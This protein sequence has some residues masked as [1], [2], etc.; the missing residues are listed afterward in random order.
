M[1]QNIDMPRWQVELQ[2]LHKQNSVLVVSGNIKDSVPF[3]V[4]GAAQ[5]LTNDLRL[6]LYAALCSEDVGPYAVVALLDQIDGLVF[7]DEVIG[8]P[9]GTEPMRVQ[10]GRLADNSQTDP[11]GGGRRGRPTTNDGSLLATLA[12]A[13]AAL[14]QT[15][16][17]CAIIVDRAAEACGPAS[18]LSAQ[19]REAYLQVLRCAV[20]AQTAPI[21]SAGADAPTR[22]LQNLLLLV[23]DRINDLPAFLWHDNAFVGRIELTRPKRDE[24]RRFFER[25]FGSDMTEAVSVTEIVDLTDGLQW[26]DLRCVRDVVQGAV[27][28]WTS[29]REMPKPRA[30]SLV[31]G[32]KFGRADSEWDAVDLDRLVH[33]EEHLTKR[34][35]GQP[36]AVRAGGDMLRR[37]TLGLAGAQQSSPTRPRGVL[38][39]AGPTGTGKTEL[40]RAIA[41]LVFGT[42]DA[43]LRFDMSEFN[44]AHAEARLVGAPPGYVGFEGGGQLTEAMLANPF[45]VVLFDEIEKAHPAILD[46]LLQ[47]VD[48]GRLTDGKGQTVY[49][50]EAIILFTSNAGVYERD[51]DGKMKIGADG[52]PLLR[53][54]PTIHSDYDTIRD[55]VRA[56]VEDYFRFELQRPELLGKIGLNNIIVFNFVTEAV[57]REILVDKMLPAVGQRVKEETGVDLVVADEVVEQLVKTAGRDISLGGRAVGKLVEDAVV[58]PATRALF[59][60]VASAAATSSSEVHD[61]HSATRSTLAG[62]RLTITG[63]VPPS[64]DNGYS[65]D[66]EHRLEPGSAERHSTIDEPLDAVT[67]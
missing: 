3:S 40:A 15:A 49:F 42:D 38:F 33:A 11:A 7:A 13:R 60:G 30:K 54:D 8:A 58:S 5:S 4:D 41:E 32:V 23:A 64:A 59:Y 43:L 45:R 20:E 67:P 34:V 16:V 61:V 51:A 47:M 52:R 12:Q 25:A 18:S 46:K 27:A 21:A 17:P 35:K 6:A 1:S 56:G 63:L 53:V 19:E 37:A 10:F 57:M 50:S 39:F 2:R 62:A 29:D 9:D 44:V 28:K 55:R 22:R 31:N 66:I 24:R 36:A 14:R 65:W 48:D 26:R